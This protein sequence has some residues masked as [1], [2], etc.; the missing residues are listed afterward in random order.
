M[1]RDGAPRAPI[2]DGLEPA[3]VVRSLSCGEVVAEHCCV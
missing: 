1:Y 3:T 2:L